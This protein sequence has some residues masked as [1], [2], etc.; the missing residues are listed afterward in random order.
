MSFD[1]APSK[2]DNAILNLLECPVCTEIMTTAIYQCKTGHSFCEI[3]NKKLSQCPIC[4]SELTNT[5]NY[6]LM[7]L[8]AQIYLPC[9]NKEIGCNFEG[10]AGQIVQHETFCLRFECPLKTSNGCTFSGETPE[11]FEH[12]LRKHEYLTQENRNV[13]WSLKLKDCT[14]TKI[15]CAYNRV[16]RSCRKFTG[17]D[18]FWTIQVYGGKDEAEAFGFSVEFERDGRKLVF[19]D[20][21]AKVTDE[22]RVFEKGLCIPWFQ[23][24]G[25]VSGDF[26][27]NNIIVIKRK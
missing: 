4:K 15:I 3:C 9:R 19:S 23:L 22:T 2:V 16:F 24:K 20:V 6:A 8:S 21:C 11:L 26:C 1:E 12:C 7:Q 13:R 10:F 17:N 5:F 14:I 18:L 27:T 25:F